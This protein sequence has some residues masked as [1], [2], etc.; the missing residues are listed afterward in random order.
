VRR[1]EREVR[2]SEC[3]R[4]DEKGEAKSRDNTLLLRRT[5]LIDAEY[6]SSRGGRPD[7]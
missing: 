6:H 4:R 7:Y 3:E 2:W 5:W 1:E